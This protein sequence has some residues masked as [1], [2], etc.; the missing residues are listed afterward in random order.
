MSDAELIS[1]LDGLKRT[2][3]RAFPFVFVSLAAMI[4]AFLG[5]V[6]TEGTTQ[7][8]CWVLMAIAFLA[9]LVIIGIRFYSVAKIKA[10]LAENLVKGY[11][12]KTFDSFDYQPKSRLGD[13]IVRSKM[14]I[15]GTID[16]ISG[17]DYI[18]GVYK[19]L[20][21]EMSDIKLIEHREH[22]NSKGELE[23]ERV[24]IFKGIWCVCDFKKPL[25]SDLWITEKSS[26]LDLNFFTV[27]TDSEVFNKRFAVRTETEVEAFYVLT[28]HMMEYIEAMDKKANGDMHFCFL[29]DGKLYIAINSGK[30][31]FEFGF[32]CDLE[33][34]KKTIEDDLSYITDFIDELMASSYYRR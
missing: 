33:S 15:S 31:S 22:R 16:E 2:Y 14:Y 12:A 27:K 11:L 25:K 18:K 10:F 28:P 26:F 4:G 5:A 8:A 30:D 7:I 17:S 1:A 32:N 23:M 19:G 3:K 34:A 13:N 24:T 9:I 6:S 29:R 21:L 20:D